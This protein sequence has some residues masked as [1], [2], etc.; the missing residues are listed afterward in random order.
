MLFAT[1][2][3]SGQ[4]SPTSSSSGSA[5]PLESAR[6][7][8]SAHASSAAPQSSST[9][10]AAIESNAASPAPPDASCVDCDYHLK[11]PWLGGIGFASIAPYFGDLSGL[12]D[13]LRAP[14]ALGA[15]YGVNRTAVLL[16]GG[17]GAVLFGKL[18][19]GGKGYGLWTGPFENARGKAALTGGGGGFEIGYVVARPRML[20]IPY[21]GLGGFA[22]NLEV[23]NL[24]SGPMTIQQQAVIGSNSSRTF[25]S[26][27]ATLDV[28]IRVQRLLFW[29][30]SGLTAGIEAGLLRSISTR[31]WQSDPVEL[32]DVSGA[33]LD[34]SYIRVNFGG[35]GF[36]F[37]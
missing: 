16:G 29:H 36:L 32:T 2:A 17:G 1:E 20:F 11:R 24:T 31:P 4:P 28:G 8:D 35:G 25:I 3:A 33:S 18:W 7:A 34:G 26:G 5:A 14:T 13:A 12:E 23:T 22:Y 21:L 27:F 9:S 30:S 6:A 10:P 19:L 15:R 37:R